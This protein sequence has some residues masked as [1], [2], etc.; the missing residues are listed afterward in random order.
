[1]EFQEWWAKAV[2][3]DI[4]FKPFTYML[5]ELKVFASIIW[6]AAQDEERDSRDWNDW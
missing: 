2:S 4:R 6:D 5:P 3:E 1:M